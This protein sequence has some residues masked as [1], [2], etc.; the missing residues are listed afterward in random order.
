MNIT[1]VSAEGLARE[2][3]ITIAAADLAS[4][5]EIKIDSIKD[6]VQLK[7]F[8]P[9]KVPLAHIRKTF[10]QQLMGEIIQETVNESSQKMLTDRDERP[11]MQPEIKLVGEADA[12]IEGKADL[13][14]DVTYE[15]IPPIELTDFSKLKLEKPVVD[16]DEAR[17]DEALERLAATRKDFAPRAKTAKAKEGDRVKIDFI[18]RIDGEAFEGGTGEGFDLELGSG[19]FIPGF[20][21]QLIGTKAGDKKDVEVNFPEE[22]GAAELAGKAAVFECTVH[23]VSEPKDAEINEEFATSL[24]MESLEK[25]KDAMREQIGQDYDQMSR[26]HMKKG[27][28]DQLS[29]SHD[30]DLPPSMVEMEFNQIWHQFEHELENNQQKL[31]DLDESEEELRAEY[32]AIAERRVRTGLVLAEVGSKNEIQVTQEEMNQGLMQRV[33]QFPGQEQQVFE[34]F[35]QNPEAMAQIRA[36]I[37]EEKVIDFICE[38]ASVSDKKVSLEQLMTE[39]GAEEAEAPKKAKPKKAPAKKAA[40]KK[41]PAKKAPA[42][43]AAAKKPAA[44]KAPAKK[45]AAKKDADKK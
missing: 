20:E 28:L 45:A 6:Q 34:Y 38:L 32:R 44:K 1:E 15:V 4:K 39:P 21:E 11:A 25:L 5:L 14:Y 16:V 2:M 23:E 7:G 27:L 33:Q 18:G 40:A 17:V 41:A 42:K 3:Q 12:I 9:G 22:Y 37:F 19:Q 13:V 8:R 43:K 31:E 29:D 35:Q 30:F 24:G 36:P 10:G 26:G